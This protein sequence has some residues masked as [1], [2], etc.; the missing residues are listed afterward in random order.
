MSTKIRP[1]QPNGLN[2]ADD[3][4]RKQFTGYENDTETNLDYAVARFYNSKLG[5]YTTA[6]PALASVVP[7]HPTSFNRYTYVENNPLKYTDPFG[8]Y[9]C[10]ASSTE[11]DQ[12]KTALDA[13]RDN[14]KKIKRD[15]GADSDQYLEAK[16]SLD[17][18]GQDGVDNKVLVNS[19][20]LAG[21]AGGGQRL[22]AKKR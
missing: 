13:A 8:L 12:F 7:E 18:Y 15:Y 3:T 1:P 17:S 11:C 19:G 20:T 4:Q 6:D 14:L 2:Y 22:E 9:I 5:R 16:R 21:N 10:T